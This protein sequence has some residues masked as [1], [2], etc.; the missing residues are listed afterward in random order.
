MV[1]NCRTCGA[2]VV[3]CE[4]CWKKCTDLHVVDG[5]AGNTYVVCMDCSQVCSEREDEYQASRTTVNIGIPDM[6]CIT[7]R[8]QLQPNDFG[9][10]RAPLYHKG[11]GEGSLCRACA[12]VSG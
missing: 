3:Y 12:G 5:Y 10:D 6:R 9:A 7:C 2:E 11:A 1:N 8:A 4:L